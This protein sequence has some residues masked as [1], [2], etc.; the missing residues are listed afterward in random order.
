MTEKPGHNG[1]GAKH[2][3]GASRR[4]FLKAGGLAG[5]GLGLGGVLAACASAAGPQGAG[6]T[7][8]PGQELLKA[9]Y[10]GGGMTV[11]W[12]P[13]GINAAK[14]LAALLNIDI[15]VFDSELSADK[16]TAN[17]EN[18]ASGSW[19]F[20]VIQ[21]IAVN[22]GVDKLQ[23]LVDKGTPIINID[24][25]I[26]DPHDMLPIHT[27]I[28]SD[29]VAM[30]EAVMDYLAA[31]INYKG[32]IVH[33]R[34][35]LSHTVA[36]ERGQGVDKALA[37]YPDI[38]VIDE[39]PGDWDAN[40]VTTIWEGLLSKGV[41]ID[42]AVFHNDSMADAGAKAIDSAGMKGKIKVGSIDAMP[43]AV[44]DVLN[45]DITV[46]AMNSA[47]RIFQDALW[48]GHYTVRENETDISPLI[49]EPSPLITADNA[50]GWSWFEKHSMW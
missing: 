44:D 35:L 26:A 14:A 40:K 39:T 34:G 43:F 31:A 11:P 47:C 50:A 12:V 38:H 32:N 45:G 23:P 7:Q 25:W 36:I 17:Y 4:D 19:D 10:I 6:S 20:V 16:Q 46:V 8:A 49:T 3:L 22:S 29:S 1:T 27:M 37:K 21:S 30:G 48:A 41:Q 28:K 13:R 24:G 2:M 18:V 9:A 5:A 42:A 15:T 33:T